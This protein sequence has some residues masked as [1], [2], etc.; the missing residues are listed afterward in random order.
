ML[1]LVS[2]T[3]E[4]IV[5]VVVHILVQLFPFRRIPLEVGQLLPQRHRTQIPRF[6]VDHLPRRRISNRSDSGTDETVRQRII[7]TSPSPEIVRIPVDPLK[8]LGGESQHGTEEYLFVLLI[9]CL[10]PR[11]PVS[12]GDRRR[13]T[14][15][16][17]QKI[18]I[19]DH[20][21]VGEHK[22]VESPKSR[23]SFLPSAGD[24]ESD[25]LQLS[26]VELFSVARLFDDEDPIPR[27]G[28]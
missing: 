22:L 10:V 3:G 11:S 9:E 8:I 18:I 23:M 26:Y 7:L 21:D 16:V 2:E 19:G 27:I 12:E 13:T 4:S 25:I 1:D 5:P 15:V 17:G 14:D 24:V 20:V 6:D 28:G